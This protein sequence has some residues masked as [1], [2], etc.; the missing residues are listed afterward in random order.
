VISNSGYC[1]DVE[2]RSRLFTCCKPFQV[3]FFVQWCSSWQDFNWF[4]DSWASCV[5][6]WPFAK[7][8]AL[9][10]G[11]IVCPVCLSVTLVYCG[12]TVGW[13]KMRLDTE[14]G[15]QQP[16]PH[17]SAFVYS[18]HMA[19]WIRIQLGME[20]SLGQGVT[21][22][23]MGTQHPQ[24]GKGHSS[25]HFSAHV[26]CGKTVTHLSSCWAVVFTGENLHIYKFVAVSVRTMFCVIWTKS[27]YLIEILIMSESLIGL[28]R[29]LL[30]VCIGYFGINS[31]RGLIFGHIW[32]VITLFIYTYGCSWSRSSSM[33]SFY[34]LNYQLVMLASYRIVNMNEIANNVNF[35]CS[36]FSL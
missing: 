12:Q 8:F 16:P 36:Q 25:P 14:V 30:F 28:Y 15:T 3:W 1:N 20:V 9:C 19:G 32:S 5:F 22:C 31:W 10:D 33:C 13:T 34:L 24:H 23:E 11:T 35:Y 7:R 29:T 17:F 26:Y 18:G 6:G 4:L 21:F 2:W 27:A